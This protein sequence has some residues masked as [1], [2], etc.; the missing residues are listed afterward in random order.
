MKSSLDSAYPP[1]Q[2][3]IV[4]NKTLLADSIP[5]ILSHSFVETPR[6]TNCTGV[7][8]CPA[9]EECTNESP[10]GS[11][12]SRISGQSHCCRPSRANSPCKRF[13]RDERTAHRWTS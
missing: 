5:V 10:P 3:L 11:C 6:G 8:S 1:N 9:Q 12:V 7:S 2:F 13:C 4:T